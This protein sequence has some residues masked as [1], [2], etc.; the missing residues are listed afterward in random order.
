MIVN[1]EQYLNWQSR[2]DSSWKFRR[3][4]QFCSNYS[5]ITLSPFGW[6]VFNNPERN[7]LL[8]EIILAFLVSRFIIAPFLTFFWPTPRPYQE[9]GFT[10]ISSVM[11]SRPTKKHNSF[12]SRHVFSLAAVAGVLLYS[13]SI[14]AVPFLIVTAITASGRIILGYHYPRDIF[15]GGILGL[16]VGVLSA[17]LI[18]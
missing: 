1:K 13:L 11:L 2:L 17:Y 12:P 4:W 18:R 15:F 5:W 14:W 3:F 7:L 16:I 6:Y 10:P 8:I 9:F